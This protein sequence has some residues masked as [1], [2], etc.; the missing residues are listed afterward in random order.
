MKNAIL[1]IALFFGSLVVRAHQPDIATTLLVEKDN[2]D[3]VLQISSSLTAFEQEIAYNFS[4]DSYSNSDEFKALL[5][6]HIKKNFSARFNTNEMIELNE[7]YV[8]LGHETN[9]V[10]KLANVPENISEVSL[11]GS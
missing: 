9:V 11:E 6:E 7:G 4:A 8:K 1:F 3:W 5:I 10:F 2:G